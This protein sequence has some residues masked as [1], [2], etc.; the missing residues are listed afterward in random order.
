[1]PLKAGD[2]LKM[3]FE[4]LEDHESP[5]LYPHT[6]DYKLQLQVKEKEQIYA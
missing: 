6:L 2:L 1:M 3:F 4:A 5:K